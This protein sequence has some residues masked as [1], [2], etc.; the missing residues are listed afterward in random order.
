MAFPILQGGFIWD[1]V[2]QGL[3]AFNYEGDKYWIYGGDLGGHRWNHDENFCNN[4]LVNPDRSIHPALNEV[5]K[6]YQPVWFEAVDIEKG[7]IKLHNYNLFT[8]LSAYTYTW[9]LVKNGNQIA[10]NSFQVKGEPLEEKV[11]N[12]KLPAIDYGSGSEFFLAVE[13][14]QRHK[15]DWGDKGHV[16]ATE[17]FAFPKNNYFIERTFTGD[18]KISKDEKELHFESGSIKGSIDLKKGRIS[19]YAYNGTRLISKPPEP[20]FWRAPTDNDFGNKM[21][22]RLNIWRTAASNLK[23]ESVEVKDQ[24][25]EG[26]EVIVNYSLFGLGVNYSIRYVI[27]HDASVLVTA[28]LNMKEAE[29]PELP[30]FGLKMQLPV[31]FENVAYYGRGPWE[32]YSDRKTSAFIGNYACKIPDLDFDYSRPQ[33]NGYRTDVR[34][35]SFTDSAGTGLLFEGINI[36]IGFNARNNAD[37]DLDPGLTK[38]QQH[39]IDVHKQ[40]KLFINIDHDQMGV[41]GNNSWGAFPLDKYRLT[42]KR[43]EYTFLMKPV[44]P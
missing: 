16:V 1:W 12:L 6:V 31:D 42:D 21:P 7:I 9:K 35:V 34:W 26:V 41:G 32:N 36:P 14:T 39:P 11:V 17:Q 4:G 44:Q 43:Y 25:A 10:G 8:D 15:T 22:S 29:L 30:R 24:T 38:K 37:D 23:V 33:E 5:K 19:D 28:T 40:D 20:N 2:D 27:Q 3:E 18:L 13:A